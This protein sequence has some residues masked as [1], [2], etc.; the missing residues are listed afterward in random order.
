LHYDRPVPTAPPKLV[1]LPGLDGSGDLFRWFLEALPP[2][3]DARVV[4]YPSDDC[5]SE[6]E[7]AGIIR[8]ACPDSDPF[9]LLAESFSTP[10]A[11]QIAAAN[12]PNL[13]GLILCAGFAANPMRSLNGAVR[14]QL[15]PLAIRLRMPAFAI[16]FW[17]LGANAPPELVRDVRKSITKVRSRVLIDRLEQISS[18]DVESELSKIVAPML[19]LRPTK[20][21][22]ISGRCL[23]AILEIKPDTEVVSIPGPHLLLQREPNQT[24]AV[25]TNFLLQHN[26]PVRTEM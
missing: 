13:K 21:R 25:I 16:K 12:P 26:Q 15:A 22:L 11:I 7:L 18:C 10:L 19:Y 20:D 8:S 24:A 2:A 1:L 5:L 4:R 14:S 23:E 9:I 6:Q 17:L 3:F